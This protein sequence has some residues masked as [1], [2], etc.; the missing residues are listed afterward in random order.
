M[1]YLDDNIT[2][3]YDAV[4]PDSPSIYNYQP[5][6]NTLVIF[7]RLLQFLHF[8]AV[9]RNFTDEYYFQIRNKLVG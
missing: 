3:E 1:N 7:Q 5:I 8:V 4:H 2:L 9:K 6:E